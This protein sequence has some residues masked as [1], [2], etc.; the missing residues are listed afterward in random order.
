MDHLLTIGAAALKKAALNEDAKAFLLQNEV[1]FNLLKKAADRY[2]GGETLE[3]TIVK[4]KQQNQQGFKCSIEFMGESTRNESESNAATAE[5]IRICEKIQQ[6]QL[7]AT[8]SLDL[9]HIGLAVAE[10]LCRENLAAI[11][12]A[13]AK[14][15]IEV[16]VSAE[17]TERTDAIINTYKTAAQTYDNL[18]ITLQAYLYRTKDDF[19]DLI[20]L[21]N[22][23]RIVKGAFETP[24]GCSM[25][26]GAELDDTYM[27]Y[28]DQLLQQRHKC[29]IATHHDKI[30]E[31]AKTLIQ[32]Y[33]PDKDSYEFESLYGIRTEQLVQLKADGYSTK[34]YFVYGKEWYLYLCNRIAEYP[35][36]IFQ[37][38]QD[39]VEA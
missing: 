4:V 5:F 8:V 18:A 23:I 14:G 33:Q 2:I 10:T 36:N 11:C 37:A 35:L 16:I 22:R 26:R 24:A 30:Q 3:E 6:Q 39:I 9:S 32:Q 28:I 38:L 17:G 21:P 20:Q 15:G 34:L 12:T 25:P 29:A 13:A 31:R 1:V 7:S 27:Y 19:K